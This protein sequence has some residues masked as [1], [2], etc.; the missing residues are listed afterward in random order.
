MSNKSKANKERLLRI[1]EFF[2]EGNFQGVVEEIKHW[3]EEIR[4][5]EI[6]FDL[7]N[8]RVVYK[9]DSQQAINTAITALPNRVNVAATSTV[10]SPVTQTALNDVNSASIYARWMP[11]RWAKGNE[12]N[13]DPT[14]MIARNPEIRY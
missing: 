12:S 2:K 4:T 13:A 6:V 7:E 3:F 11:S 8:L 10:T 1:N 14:S 5:G 9:R